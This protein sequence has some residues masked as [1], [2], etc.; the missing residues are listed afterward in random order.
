MALSNSRS[1]DG[2]LASRISFVPVGGVGGVHV[3]AVRHVGHVAGTVKLPALP[4]V[5]L[6]YLRSVF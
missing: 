3:T 4:Q 6:K 5:R 1:G 2:E